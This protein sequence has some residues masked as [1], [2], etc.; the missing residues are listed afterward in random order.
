M[1]FTPTTLTVFGLA[2]EI[3]PPARIAVNVLLPPTFSFTALNLASSVFDVAYPWAL[4]FL[5][6]DGIRRGPTLSLP[7]LLPSALASPSSETRPSV[8]FFLSYRLKFLGLLVL[9]FLFTYLLLLWIYL[10]PLSLYI[11]T[12]SMF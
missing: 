8:S 11:C 7:P 4:F 10:M 9:Y 3:T 12:V 2:L 1:P 6:H 5:F